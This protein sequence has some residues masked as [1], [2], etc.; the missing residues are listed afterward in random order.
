M[1]DKQTKAAIDPD[2]VNRWCIVPW[3]HHGMRCKDPKQYYTPAEFGATFP[4]AESMVDEGMMR[5]NA[6]RGEAY[7]LYRYDNNNPYP[8][9]VPV[10]MQ[11]G[12]LEGRARILRRARMILGK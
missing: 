1:R 7:A 8:I 11:A 2:Y 6:H 4:G 12:E 3:D 9:F 10:E 5:R